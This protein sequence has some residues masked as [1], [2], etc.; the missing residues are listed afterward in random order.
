M[1]LLLRGESLKQLRHLNLFFYDDDDSYSMFGVRSAPNFTDIS[2][3]CRNVG[4]IPPNR[5]K[6]EICGI[7]LPLGEILRV[8]RES[9]ICT[10]GNLPPCKGA[11]TVL[12]NRVSV[13]ANCLFAQFQKCDKQT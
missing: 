2:Y 12:L 1:N 6:L 4:V 3:R 5:S 8:H 7:N 11:I 13:F 9:R 10:T